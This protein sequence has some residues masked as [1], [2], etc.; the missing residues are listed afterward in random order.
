MRPVIAQKRTKCYYC[1]E[2]ILPGARR[3]DDV[4]RVKAKAPEGK[5][6]RVI[7]RHF[8]YRR[9]EDA[10]QSCFDIWSE[11]IFEKLPTEVRTNNP[12]GRPKLDLTDFQ[13]LERAKLLRRLSNQIHYYIHEGHLDL[14]TPKLPTEISVADVKKAER[15]HGNVKGILEKLKD[16]GGIPDRFKTILPETAEQAV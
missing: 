13:R 16:L 9:D 3:L 14:T 7:T 2:I 6:P 10:T 11:E 12:K 8:C 4:L 5:T 1:K 15:F